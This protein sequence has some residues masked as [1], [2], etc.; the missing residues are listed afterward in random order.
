MLTAQAV[1][2]PFTPKNDQPKEESTRKSADRYYFH[3]QKE[4]VE[5]IK[6]YFPHAIFVDEG[7]S[8]GMVRMFI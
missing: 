1:P 4:I 6:S 2:G 8:T 3:V 5:K 7:D